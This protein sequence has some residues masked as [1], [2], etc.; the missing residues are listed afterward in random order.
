MIKKQ[1]IKQQGHWRAAA[2]NHTVAPAARPKLSEEEIRRKKLIGAIED[3]HS[4]RV[5]EIIQKIN[6]IMWAVMWSVIS[7]RCIL[8]GTFQFWLPF[9]I[10]AAL[11][12]YV[13]LFL[14]AGSIGDIQAELKALRKELEE[15]EKENKAHDT[16]KNA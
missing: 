9:A 1:R 5:S 13:L 6:K 2:A 12:F 8:S 7:A 15:E 14:S 4:R 10:M 3:L 11:G 16:V